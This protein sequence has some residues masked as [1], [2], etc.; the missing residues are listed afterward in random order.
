MKMIYS[1]PAPDSMSTTIEV[2]SDP[3]N[4]WYEWRILDGGRTVNRPGFR[5][6]LFA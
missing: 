2:Y 5:G 1:L 4:A 3:D 6:G